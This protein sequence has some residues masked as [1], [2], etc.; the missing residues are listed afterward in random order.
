MSSLWT[1]VRE[2]GASPALCD[3]TLA[4][5]LAWLHDNGRSASSATLVLAAVRFSRARG[6]GAVSVAPPL[7]SVI[8]PRLEF[9]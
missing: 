7:P 1:R 8:W 6:C 4:E 9:L 3:A 2:R 5:Y